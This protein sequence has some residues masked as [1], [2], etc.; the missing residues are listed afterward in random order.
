MLFGSKF[1]SLKNRNAVVDFRLND[2]LYNFKLLV[3][4]SIFG[5]LLRVID[6]FFIRGVSLSTNVFEN[7]EAL[8]SGTNIIAVIS[9]FLYPMVFLIP[10]YFLLISKCYKI[11]VIKKIIL[12]FISL[13]PIFDGLLFGSRSI[14]LS[15]IALIFLYSYILGF[16]SIKIKGCI[17]FSLFVLAMLT[18][19]GFLFDERTSLMGMSAID[20]TR[21]S[22][23]AYFTPLN[24]SF[25]YYLKSLNNG[26]F[27]YL[28]LGTLNFIQYM[29]HGLF[30]MLFLVDTFN[31]D[32][33]YW[34]AQN[35]SFIFKF[36]S[37][38]FWI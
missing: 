9:S 2:V 36:M 11:N 24:E 28:L 19:S 37:S 7:R 33:I 3:L 15:F 13:Y 30:E 34:G 29:I 38:V 26:F 12:I 18:I 31:T 25:S 35:L 16:I 8:E 14:I 21:I 22:V 17:Y 27:Y 20:S 4:I 5:V 1:I 23:Y 10:F 6:R 32:N